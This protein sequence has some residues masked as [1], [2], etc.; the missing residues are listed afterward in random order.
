MVQTINVKDL[1]K[2]VGSKVLEKYYMDCRRK[3]R[4]N[5]SNIFVS[6]GRRVNILINLKLW[7]SAYAKNFRESLT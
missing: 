6:F 7:L 1:K 3:N 4:N 2:Q 5:Y